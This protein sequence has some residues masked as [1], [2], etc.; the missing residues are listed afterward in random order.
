MSVALPLDADEF[1]AP[2]DARH[3]I[4]A[5][6][7]YGFAHFAAACSCGWHG[8]RRYLKAGAQLDAWQHSAQDS[9]AVSVPLVIPAA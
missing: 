9:C 3:G 8:R 1:F 4:V 5:V 2:D 6:F 7:A